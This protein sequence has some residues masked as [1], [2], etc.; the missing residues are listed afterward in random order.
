MKTRTAF[1]VV[2]TILIA[3]SA[4]AQTKSF[5]EVVMLG[6]PLEVQAAISRGANVNERDMAGGTPL[7]WACNLQYFKVVDILLKAG[8]DVNAQ[9]SNGFTALMWAAMYYEVP[10]RIIELLDAGADAK[11][12][13]KAGKTALDL[14]K[15]NWRFAETEGYRRLEA[16]SK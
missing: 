12:E 10:D 13:D 9:D 16:A 15:F 7:M 8:A 1:L 4:Y 6:G 5:F 2:L 14:A 11:L 3:A